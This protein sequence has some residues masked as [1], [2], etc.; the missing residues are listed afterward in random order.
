[1]EKEEKEEE[2]EEGEEGVPAAS[3]L[4]Q[5]SLPRQRQLPHRVQVR[6]WPWRRQRW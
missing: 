1:M 6:A 5:D 2:E 3:C 4:L